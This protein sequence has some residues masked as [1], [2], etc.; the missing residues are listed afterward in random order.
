MAIHTQG[1]AR[2]GPEVNDEDD[3]DEEGDEEYWTGDELKIKSLR[4][5]RKIAQD[6]SVKVPSRATKKHLVKAMLGEEEDD[7]AEEEYGEEEEKQ[8]MTEVLLLN[9]RAELKEMAK[10]WGTTPRRG[11]TKLDLI[12]AI[13][14]AQF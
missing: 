6:Q 3:E 10:R 12:N 1:H 13:I 9:S 14:A 5:L 11:A 4:A 7:R 2:L 8:F